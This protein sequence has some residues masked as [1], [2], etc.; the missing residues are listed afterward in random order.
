M[1]V[2][3][4][5]DTTSFDDNGICVLSPTLCNVTEVA[6][7]EYEL[8]M[9]HPL[10]DNGKY[11]M[12][13]EERL[14]KAPVPK[15]YIP[16][17]SLPD[18]IEWRTIR[19]TSMYSKVPTYKH[20]NKNWHIIWSVRENPFRYA[21]KANWPY[22]TGGIALWGNGI[23]QAKG[24][25]YNVTPGTNANLWAYIGSVDES[26]NVIL[27]GGKLI[28][29]L[30]ANTIIYYISES[31][32]Y[33]KVRS[34]QGT[35][36]VK[37]S[38]CNETATRVAQSIPPQTITHQIFRIY[39]T[40]CE[41]ETNM[42]TVKA[43]HISYDFRGNMLQ[44]CKLTDVD[45]NEA[46]AAIQTNLMDADTRTI[47]S[48]ITGKQITQDWSFKNPVNALLDPSTG[49]VA[50]TNAKLIRNNDAFYILDS[51]DKK[52]GISL[53][54]GVNLI[55]VKWTRNVENV[56]TRVVPKSGN[57]QNGYTYITNGGRLTY[58][59]STQ[60]WEVTDSG[61]Q[62]VES[63]SADD[64]RNARY[65]VLNC[66]YSQ[67]QAYEDNK[68]GEQKKYT[69]EEV[70]A[71]MLADAMEQFTVKKVDEPTIELEVEFLLLGDTEEYKQYKGLQTVNLYDVVPVKTGKSGVDI[72]V[73][74]T[75]YEYDSIRERY[76]S[77]KLGTINSFKRRVPGYRVV[78]ESVTAEKLD[79]DLLNLIRT[80][81]ASESADS[82][83]VGITSTTGGAE[84]IFIPNTKDSDGIVAAG[85]GY[86]NKVW[87]TDSEGNPAW[88]DDSQAQVAV[89]DSNPTLA[90]GSQSKVGDVAGTDLHVTMPGAKAS[91]SVLLNALDEDTSA[92]SDNDLT[93][94]VAS[95]S[96]KVKLSKFW[97]YI[98]GKLGISSSGST[99]KYLNEQGG[100]ATPTD[101]KNTAGSTDSSSKLFLVGATSQ[102]A[103]PQTYS[104]DTAYVGTD[105][106]L[107]SNS[108]KVKT[109]Q[110][111]VSDPT[112]SGSGIDYIASISQNANGVITATKST[113]RSASDT[114]S[115]VVTTGVQTFAGQKAFKNAII[116]N[117]GE[118]P[119]AGVQ[120][121]ILQGKYKNTGGTVDLTVN[122][123][124][125]IGSSA[126]D[127]AYNCGVALGSTS[128]T[129]LV[130]AG[131]SA[132]VFTSKNSIYN[133][134][135]LY[136]TADGT[137]FV[138]P[139]VA[140]DGT[141]GGRYKFTS[142]SSGVDADMAKSVKSISRS[143]TTFTA[144][145]QDGTTF[146]FTQQD[147]NTWKANSSSSEG[148]VASGSGQ[149]N[150]VWKTDG[151]GNP[152]WRD[153]DH[154]DTTKIPLITGS[155]IA[156]CNGA[157]SNTYFK[158][159]T[160]TITSTYVNR[161]IVFEISRRGF[162][163]QR[164]EVIFNNSN[165]LDPTLSRFAVDGES[166][167]FWIKK[168]TTSVWE[169]Y[170]QYNE[171]YGVAYLHR[172]TG[173]GTNN[174]ITVTVNMENAGTTAP[175][176][177]AATHA[178]PFSA[179][180]KF[181]TQKFTYTYTL[182]AGSYLH[183]TK[184]N[185]GITSDPQDWTGAWVTGFGTGYRTVNVYFA[186]HNA[187]SNDVMGIRNVGSSQVE[188]TCYVYL[189][190]VYY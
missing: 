33:L 135:N 178:Y 142:L 115:G 161:P 51:D 155:G 134:E 188:A 58:N 29:T 2:L 166:T 129:T 37:K 32:G 34:Q 172:I 165:G 190:R 38:D 62:Y 146:T 42:Y 120:S 177:T 73:Q 163:F 75:E 98:K 159:A 87:K 82:M 144:T 93:T 102:A 140:N 69:Q 56:V 86:A 23:Y 141:P 176:G 30:P 127:D 180:P 121:T 84:Q 184:A 148:Y 106:C 167:S 22:N 123:V 109:T 17:T 48:N 45:V 77:I 147:N 90:F 171:S 40:G 65:S 151:S 68:T 25:C 114:Q 43:R 4:E 132:N 145:C 158:I 13:T 16:E 91:A 74:V 19:E 97:D 124:R 99:S 63:A 7:G 131:E 187:D 46:I 35:G 104:H 8:E 59:S 21:Y 10:D 47:A 57:S 186:T 164:I 31:G 126:G 160:L 118:S 100:W 128:G 83:D 133:D 44:E 3:Y 138:Y 85:S 153:D 92:L 28:A 52:A 117:K 5:K 50:K 183:V 182:A 41:E 119:D 9:E 108:I 107:Y 179:I 66:T 174:G 67:G 103:N 12:L 94:K 169:I 53:T 96:K 55:G 125:Y 143:G 76:N 95:T 18:L 101:T 112:A 175:G 156:N 110:T 150:K 181:S 1:I 111:A 116:V 72:D 136:L 130:G 6:G 70:L 15:N 24:Y 81:D 157:G 149:A 64:Y 11:L 49:V 26:T 78:N 105:G 54:Y 189:T 80:S 20:K 79:P 185:L 152:A 88:R 27:D 173:Y 36:F 137:V 14:I 170:G 168:K 139:G 39:E 113:V 122:P 154:T 61:K 89:N 71:K 162:G 60:K